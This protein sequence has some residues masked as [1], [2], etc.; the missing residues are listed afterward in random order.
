MNIKILIILFFTDYTLSEAIH[1]NFL[2]PLSTSHTPLHATLHYLMPSLIEL[3]AN[4]IQ[5]LASTAT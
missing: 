1:S 3:Y 5:S 2:I 4:P